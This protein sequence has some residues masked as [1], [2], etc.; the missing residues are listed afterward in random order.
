MLR[1]M[2]GTRPDLV[3]LPPQPES[4][5][6]PTAEWPV[7]E[8]DPRVDRPALEKLLDHAFARPDPEDLDRTHAVVIVQL[9]HPGRPPDWPVQHA[10]LERQPSARL[11]YRGEAVAI[12]LVGGR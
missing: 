8:L 2:A 1:P 12:W 6:W 5:P 3:P 7:A 11:A 10:L 4:V 9:P